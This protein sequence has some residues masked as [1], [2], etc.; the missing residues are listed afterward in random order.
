[1]AIAFA[2]TVATNTVVVTGGTSGVPATFADFVTADRAGTG[3]SLKAAS[4]ASKTYTLTYA[5][6]PVELLAI[7]VK[8]IVAAKT[9]E[10]D[11]LF[12]T[13]TDAWD[14]AQTENIDVS[15]GNGTYTSTKRWRTITNISCSDAT[16]GTGTV[17]ADGTLAVTQD[18][19]GAIWNKGNSQYQLDSPFF[20]GNEVTSSYFRTSNEE[21]TLTAIEA[22]YGGISI[23]VTDNAT[24]QAGIL[25]DLT[26]KRTS[27]GTAFN[28][29]YANISYLFGL[30]AGSGIIY[31]YSSWFRAAF[32]STS[33]GCG[34]DS[35]TR[36]WNCIGCQN[37]LFSV[38][39]IGTD[40]S[41]FI[42][43]KSSYAGGRAAFQTSSSSNLTVTDCAFG[44]YLYLTGNVSFINCT[45]QGSTTNALRLYRITA[46]KYLDNCT[47][48]SWGITDGGGPHTYDLWRRYYCDIH[49]VDKD[50]TN[51]A[52]ATVLCQDKDG[53]T[54][55]SVSTDANGNIAQQTIVYQKFDHTNSWAAV[56]YSPHKFTIS[57]AG[58]QTLVLD[59]ITVNAPIKWH[60]ELQQPSGGGGSLVKRIG[61]GVI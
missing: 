60:L 59:A 47:F 45:I 44:V 32:S 51:L 17:W 3:T 6:R 42:V 54:A 25:E 18:I 1:M 49:V 34:I 38:A 56:T 16:D 52:S 43:E 11:Y 46:D 36:L 33:S 35:A 4:A 22:I 10:T 7:V 57:K 8:C 61:T 12:I 13:G 2:Y 41:N 24:F 19:W 9:T 30:T 28:S 5:V 29:V 23:A 39:Y 58:Y 50:G 55:F 31:L 26:T 14:A 40:I 20:V 27:R 53:T 15:A 48:D 21:I 37:I